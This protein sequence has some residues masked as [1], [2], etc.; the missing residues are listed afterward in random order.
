MFCMLKLLCCRI[1]EY[2]Q[3]YVRVLIHFYTFSFLQNYSKCVHNNIQA[4]PGLANQLRSHR[5][6][7]TSLTKCGLEISDAIF[8]LG[9][10]PC[11]TELVKCL[12]ILKYL[13]RDCHQK[14]KWSLMF[15]HLHLSLSCRWHCCISN[16]QRY[17]ARGHHLER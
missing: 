6:I 10:H 2:T 1:L 11:S 3:I 7:S 13:L 16:L 9:M 14:L 15:Q 8:V 4:C 12:N 17:E 5:D